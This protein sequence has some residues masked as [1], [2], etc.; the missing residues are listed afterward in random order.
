VDYDVTSFSDS[1]HT[2]TGTYYYWLTALDL[3]GNES[4]Y[5]NVDSI[6]ITIVGIK[7][8][9][10]SIV[11]D[12]ALHQNYPNP[13]NPSTTIRYSVGAHRDVTLQHVDLSIYNTLGQKV[14]TL[15]NK[16]QSAG[17]YQI[18]WNAGGLSSGV[19]LYRLQTGNY[20]QTK[21]MILMK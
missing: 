18:K 9:Q 11:N 4:E 14:A 10:Q 3:L 1:S 13:F 19:Y 8:M 20:I 12:F 16:K 6:E 5:S 15:V 2:E 21:K 7:D 17:S